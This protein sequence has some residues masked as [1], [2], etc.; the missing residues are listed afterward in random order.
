MSAKPKLTLPS[1]IAEF[2]ELHAEPPRSLI[3]ELPPADPFPVYALDKILGDAA[4]G[5]NDRVQAPMAI[6]GQSVL[7]VATLAVQGHADIQLPTGQ[8]K[9][10]SNFF[11]TVAESGARKTAADNEALWPIKKREAALREVYVNELVDYQNSKLAWEEAQKYSIKRGKGDRDAIRHELDKLGPPPSPPVVPLL[12]CPEPTYEGLVKHLAIGHPS[13]GIFS[14]E[15]GQF[16]GGHGMSDDAKLRTA[17]GLSDLWDGGEIKRVRA[18]D[19]SIILP[20]R[21]VAMHLLAQPGVAAAMLADPKLLDQGL[22][23][24]CLVTAPESIIGTRMW[25][26][27]VISSETAIKAYGAR[28]LSIMERSL[29]LVTGK[30]NELAPRV[31]PL[32]PN[33]RKVWIKFADS[34]EVQIK[35]DGPLAPVKG[36]A[37]KLA[38]HAVR[39]AATLALVADIEASAI[40]AEHLAH[41]I[42]LAQH[43]AAEAL[44]L[45]ETSQ[46]DADLLLAKKLLVWLTGGAWTEDAIS[47]PDIYQN[48][49]NAI[50]DQATARR[51]VGI[52]E[53]HGW[54]RRIEG[55]AEVNG[56][57]RRDAWQIVRG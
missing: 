18:S 53:D 36:L 3:R 12:T 9:P 52:L 38:E 33:A 27:P 13:V 7:A 22:L 21:R 4:N 54:L 5:I 43:Y 31:L 41:G 28:M 29:P 47:L 1:S 39:L 10:I 26:E 32:A 50:R 35:S 49:P 6:C 17:A 56:H 42:I 15:G 20:G 48:G 46:A 34:I 55:G 14:S 23:S 11:V 30:P 45:F 19:G 2:V 40:S 24:R 51:L 8:S 25:H 57:R 37:N 16:I 44:R